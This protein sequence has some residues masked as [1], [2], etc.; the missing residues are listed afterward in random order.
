ME[1]NPALIKTSSIRK[2]LK[3]LQNDTTTP[4]SYFKQENTDDKEDRTK[5][6]HS[7]LHNIS[8]RI[9]RKRVKRKIKERNTHREQVTLSYINNESKRNFATSVERKD[10]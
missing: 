2:K 9:N 1:L 7:L 3:P 4:S 6:K 8:H 5:Q 10:I